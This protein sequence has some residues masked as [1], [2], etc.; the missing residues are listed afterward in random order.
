VIGQLINEF[1][2][3]EKPT[4]SKFNTMFKMYLKGSEDDKVVIG[5]LTTGGLREVF[6]NKNM[7][8]IELNLNKLPVKKK[9]YKNRKKPVRVA[10]FNYRVTRGKEV[11]KF[12]TMKETA[13]FLGLQYSG[14]Y[15]RVNGIYK[16][17]TNGWKIQQIKM[18]KK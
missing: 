15:Y 9:V 2:S 18:E 5:E 13:T 6:I 4:L 1:D 11:E 8:L 14:V 12:S 16:N 10:R 3:L 7:K 17:D